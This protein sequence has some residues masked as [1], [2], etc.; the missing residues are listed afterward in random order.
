MNSDEHQVNETGEIIFEP[1]SVP[2]CPALCL[3]LS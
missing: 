1:H 2:F 3:S